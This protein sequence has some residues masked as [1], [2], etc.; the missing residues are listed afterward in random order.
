[1]MEESAT[2]CVSGDFSQALEKAKEADKKEKAL[3]KQRERYGLV[4]QINL[5][6]TYA[7]CFNLANCY[8]QNGMK[9]EA[10]REYGAIVKNK[11]Y[12]QAGRLRANMGN[13]YYEQRE[14]PEAI[15]N[16][17]MALDQ[18]CLAH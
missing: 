11:Q 7:V 16:Y 6:L 14:Y 12:P 18:V 1:M 9:K 5:D 3:C 15:K 8:H 10:L 13:I 2:A 17:R 4:D